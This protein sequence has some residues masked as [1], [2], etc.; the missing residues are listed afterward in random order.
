MLES[1]KKNE[2]FTYNKLSPEEMKARRILGRLVGPCAEFT[3]PTRNGRKYSEPLWENVFNDDIVKEKI[4]NKCLFGELGH[5]ADREEVDPEKIAIALNEVPKK[6]ADGQLIACFDILDTPTGQ[7]LKTLCDYGSTIGISS[8]GSGDI[9]DGPNGEELVDPDTY[10]FECFDAV[11]LPAVKSAR[12]SYMTESFDKNT[13]AMK[14]A[15]TES[16]QSADAKDRSIMKEALGN[17]NITLDEAAGMDD[18]VIT[19]NGVNFI[20]HRNPAT[21][22]VGKFDLSLLDKDYFAERLTEESEETKDVEDVENIEVEA[23]VEEVE[24]IEVTEDEAGE[25]DLLTLVQEKIIP[26]DEIKGEADEGYNKAI[27][28]VL[29]LIAAQTEE[30]TD[31]KSV[32]DIEENSDDQPVA[33]TDESPEEAVDD[34]ADEVIES[35]KDMVRQKDLLEAEVKSLKNE[36]TVSDTKAAALAEELD[37]YKTAFGR[38]SELASKSTKFE[39]QVKELN[40]QLNAKDAQITELKN[41]AINNTALNESINKAASEKAK[42]TQKIFDMQSEMQETEK[43]LNEQLSARKAEVEKKT[44]IALSYKAKFESVVNKYIDTKASMLGVQS[45]EIRNRLTEQFSLEDVDKVCEEFLSNTRAAKLPFVG[46]NSGTVM[47]ESK[48]NQKFAISKND[49]LYDL[50]EL[51]GLN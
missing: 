50:Y 8:R 25:K 27:N 18:E 14:K 3:I 32:E 23:P 42:L 9:I 6:N 45:S 19:K 51:A 13:A 49:D 38:V 20:F 33:E 44:K 36:K 17:L 28:E 31:D 12:L 30:Q 10:N 40:E 41:K 48:G 46:R 37:K 43:K 15:L 4:A 7:I 11:L 24:E 16:L 47:T 29:E 35:L 5:P 26:E 2:A 39:K 1:L 22:P 34:G 21:V